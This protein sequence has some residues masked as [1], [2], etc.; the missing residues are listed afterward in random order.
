[1]VPGSP[2]FI[3][4]LD[5]DCFFVSVERI[6]NPSLR[7]KPVA[8]GGSPEGRGVVASA[9]YEARAFGVHSAMPM[10]RALRLCPDLI[11]VSGSH[12]K[13]GEY[14]NR[15]TD[16]LEEVSPVVERCSIDEMNLD[17]T[18]CESLYAN[19]LEGFLRSLKQRIWETFQ[20]PCT[21]ALASNKTLAKIAANTVKPGGLI[22]VPHGTEAAF[23]APLPVEAIPG[24]GEKT[25]ETLHRFGLRTIAQCQEKSEQELMQILGSY[26]ASLH[27]IAHGQGSVQLTPHRVRKSISKEET[28]AADVSD[29]AVL[30]TKL[31]SMVESISYTLRRRQ[32]RARTVTLKLRYADFTTVTRQQACPPTDLDP[33]IFT[34]ARDL[35]RQHHQAGRPLR[36]I[37]V[38]VSNLLEPGDGDL[39]LFDDDEHGNAA[40]AAADALRKRF[41]TE[42]IHYAGSQHR[43]AK[44][45][46]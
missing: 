2:K 3:A 46:Q 5:L 13:Y 12:G 26:G 17:L 33:A 43:P 35:L 15:L 29:A 18:G 41:G 28:F 16:L 39:Q 14:S 19:D 21:I 40:L 9:S 31:Y 4:H 27:R 10:A 38:G 34:I 42:I 11:V 20:L 30:E 1:M 44:G 45:R 24:V 23:L 6:F 36:L 25:A 8:V 37:G 7:G 32:E 22:V